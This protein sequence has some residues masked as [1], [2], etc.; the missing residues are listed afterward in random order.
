MNRKKYR[1]I[2]Y[3]IS[4][5]IIVT[6][7]IQFY[8]NYRN[9]EEN[10]QNVFNEITLS[11][12]N[13]L[14]E[15]YAKYFKKNIKYRTAIKK[16]IGKDSFNLKVRAAQKIKNNSSTQF[17]INLGYKRI[18]KKQK[19]SP[20]K[21]YNKYKKGAYQKKN[22]RKL[23]NNVDLQKRLLPLFFS[24]SSKSINFKTLD[25]LLQNQLTKKSLALKY[26]IQLLK[27]DSLLFSTKRVLNTSN[28]IITTSSKS[29]FLKTSEKIELLYENP[30]L[31]TL[32]KGIYGIL[33]SLFFSLL[34]I[35]C[36]FYLLHIIHKQKELAVIKNDLISNITHEFK[37][38]IATV[39]SAIEAMENFNILEDA[40]KT[41]KYLAISSLQLKKLHQMVEK[42][43]ETSILDN[44]ALVLK[45]EQTD[46]VEIIKKSITKYQL[47]HQNK[48]ISFDS[49]LKVLNIYLD[50][51][52]FENVISNLIDNAVKYG[53]TTIKINI[54]RNSKTTE[55]LII[56]NGNG[57]NKNQQEKIF[58][59][60]YRVPQGNTHNVKGFGIG[61]YYCKKIIEQHNGLLTLTSSKNKTIF[62]L[63]FMNE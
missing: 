8:W 10:K 51:F 16:E 28:E 25:S 60:F 37:T 61:L 47:L 6:I 48:H 13:A 27:N 45:K 7:A 33:I 62:K 30:K 3:T 39:S 15:Y 59:Q 50:R 53:G 20:N 4:I 43:L 22:E 11:L 14:E 54:K 5:T 44:K 21:N 26:N 24:M 57:I 42:I 12:D 36:L 40:K 18:T 55:I 56:D 34:I 19:I 35:S 52:H 9:Y 23:Y 41:K 32:K 29:S 63:I 1:F 46:V 49:D 31:E 2:F 58:D 38:P 17:N